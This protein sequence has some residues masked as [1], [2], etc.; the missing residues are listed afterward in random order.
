MPDD[1]TPQERRKEA[2]IKSERSSFE[3]L[4]DILS[5]SPPHSHTREGIVVKGETMPD[6]PGHV[7]QFLG[8]MFVIL[9][10]MIM[11]LG[12]ALGGLLLLT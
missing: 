10:V 9:V 3:F 5:L 6:I 2:K 4:L 1:R 12:A 8:V 7:F 11:F